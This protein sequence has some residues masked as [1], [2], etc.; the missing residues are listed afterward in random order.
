[1]EI[2]KVNTTSVKDE[3][4]SHEAVRL[5]EMGEANAKQGVQALAQGEEEAEGHRSADGSWSK[6]GSK[7]SGGRGSEGQQGHQG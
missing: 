3:G 6:R 4:V 1:M 7:G 5:R 2:T